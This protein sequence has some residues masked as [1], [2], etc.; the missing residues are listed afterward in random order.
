ML[1]ASHYSQG[2]DT[3]AWLVR[4]VV[5]RPWVVVGGCTG[6]EREARENFLKS[7]IFVDSTLGQ[8]SEIPDWEGLGLNPNH[9]TS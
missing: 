2:D 9:V 6:E 3:Y 5:N 1:V 4:K 8:L 7:L